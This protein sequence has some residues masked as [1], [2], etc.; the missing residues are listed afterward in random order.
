[1]SSPSH[2]PTE[3][4]RAEAPAAEPRMGKIERSLREARE[5]LARLRAELAR[6]PDREERAGS[7]RSNGTTKE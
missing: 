4:P 1:M 7:S 2:Q 3:A 6:L 5:A